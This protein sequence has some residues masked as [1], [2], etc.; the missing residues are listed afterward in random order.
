MS[1][2]G[3]QLGVLRCGAAAVL[4][5]VTTPIA[6]SIAGETSAPL[7]AGL[8]Y[9]GAATAVAPLARRQR[10]E[11]GAA[12]RNLRPLAIA[13]VAGGFLGPLLLAAGLAR[14]PAATA[15][16]LLNLE[17]VATTILAALFFGEH[18]GRPILTGTVLVTSAGA[19]LAWSGAPELRL[20]ALLVAAA[21]LCWGLDNCVT[22]ALDTIAPEH[23][24]LAKGAIAGTTN[25]A[26]G[27]ALGGSLPSGPDTVLALVAGGFGYGLSITLWV[28]GARNLGAARG[29][30]VF[31]AAPFLGVLVAW[32]ALG[33]PVRGVEVLALVLA[34]V[35][36]LRVLRSDHEHPHEHE[37]VVHDHEHVHDEHH[38][39]HDAAVVPRHR[40]LHVHEPLVHAHPHVPDLHHR[41]PHG[42]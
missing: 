6:S 42:S 14:T 15:S 33:E 7:L 24:T 29:Q 9:L 12:R 8:L 28:A 16:L 1:L 11:P 26:L 38:R 25:L 2:Q 5:G 27:L 37:R 23:I 31:A 41:H 10:L 21:C 18:L 13:V 34:V 40:H 22:A 4:F 3:S 39:H 36:V 30:L 17:L 35:G 19:A 20:G 32:V